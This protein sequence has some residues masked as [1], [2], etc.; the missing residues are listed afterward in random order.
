MK[1]NIL[2]T[3][4]GAVLMLTSCQ[5]DIEDYPGINLKDLALTVELD[6]M[7]AGLET[8]TRAVIVDPV[9][10]E[11]VINDLHLLFFKKANDGTTN[12]DGHYKVTGAIQENT[13]ITLNYKNANSG[14]YSVL[15]FANTDDFNVNSA[16]GSFTNFLNSISSNNSI[17]DVV[18][19][20]DLFI[21]A[22]PEAI[23]ANKLFMSGRAEKLNDNP[24]ISLKLTR[25]VCRFDLELKGNSHEFEKIFI[26]NNARSTPMWL[27]S[28][29]ANKKPEINSGE[30]YSAEEATTTTKVEGKYYAFENFNANPKLGDKNTTCLVVGI[31]ANGSS[32]NATYYRININPKGSSQSLKRNFVYK[33]SINAVLGEGK[34]TPDEA[35]ELATEPN[36]DYDINNWKIDDEGIIVTDGKNTLAIPSKTIRFAKEGGE[37]VDDVFTVGEGTLTMSANLPNGFSAVL[38]QNQLTV[39]ADDLGDLAKREGTITL[40]YAGLKATISVIQELQETEFVRVDKTL[41]N[42]YP[43]G[44]STSFTEDINVISSGKWKAQIYNTGGSSFT[45]TPG[46]SDVSTEGVSGTNINIYA[47]DENPYNRVLT[48]FVLISLKDFPEFNRVVML[49]QKATQDIQIDLGTGFDDIV[50]EADGKV[51]NKTSHPGDYFQVHVTPPKDENGQVSTNWGADLI[52]A[53]K[54]KFEIK[55]KKQSGS[56]MVMVR[57]VYPYFNSSSSRIEDVTLRVYPGNDPNTSKTKTVAVWQEASIKELIDITETLSNDG[58]ERDV[59]ID[60]PDGISWEVKIE[61]INTEDNGTN[62]AQWPAKY[63]K[64]IHQGYLVDGQ[65]K[66]TALNA[67]VTGTGKATIIVGFPKI[68]FPLVGVEPTLSL[69]IYT[70]HNNEKAGTIL[71]RQQKLVPKKIKIL[72]NIEP[73]P[74]GN[75]GAIGGNWFKAYTNCITKSF[76]T[77]GSNCYADIHITGEMPTA[78]NLQNNKINYLHLGS[79]KTSWESEQYE[80]IKNYREN[81]K[82]TVAVYVHDAYTGSTDK[83]KI[84]L[85]YPFNGSPYSE[86][87]DRT[88]TKKWNTDMATNTNLGKYLFSDGPFG[89]ADINTVSSKMGTIDLIHSNISRDSFEKAGGI[90]L[91]TEYYDTN[92]VVLGINPTDNFIF[93]GEPQIFDIV[94]FDGYSGAVENEKFLKNFIS[95]ILRT[96]QYGSHFTDHFQPG[97]TTYPFAEMG[98]TNPDPMLQP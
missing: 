49:K 72:N 71:V 24:L 6:R 67:S 96:A 87:V 90:T 93:L 46:V 19:A 45:F 51:R 77:L 4:A 97:A 50:F 31:R 73:A 47:K 81:N 17:E 92:R 98:A 85:N 36:L 21:K 58:E 66:I 28:G 83:T 42:N 9:Q 3:I 80:S 39:K 56:E 37:R 10:G 1:R 89:T 95:Y 34:S 61:G 30:F 84:F 38:S 48:G 26:Y 18:N 82:E 59:L 78:T 88:T 7:G 20:T 54:G 65:S 75:R 11:S 53:N 13:K 52:G 79:N 43:A 57:P 74:N 44:G 63:A 22:A 68:L 86:V 69:V 29:N 40:N 2:Y 62:E 15:A 8:E 14:N 27:S 91:I 32:D 70:T 64:M 25:A 60:L 33:V 76:T 5:A 23:K 55:L 16:S 35:Y 41:V 12:F 94:G